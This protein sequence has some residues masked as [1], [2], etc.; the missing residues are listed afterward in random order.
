MEISVIIVNYNVRVFLES[1]LHS[2]QKG[3]QGLQGEIFVVDNASQD[4][5]VAM[6][7]ER[8]P[9]IHLIASDVNLGFGKANNRAMH[10]CKGRYLLILNPDTIIQEDTLRTMIDFMDTHP[11]AGMAGCKVLNADGTFQLSC[12][13]GF[14]TPW[15]SFCKAFGLSSIFPQVKTFAGYNLT[16]LDE[17]KSYEIDALAGS[18]MMVRREVLQQTG[19]FDEDYFMYGEDLDWC[20]RTKKI[21]WKIWYT[22]ATQIIHYKGESAKRSNM[23]EVRIFYEAMRIFVRKNFTAPYIFISFLRIG[24]GM[25]SFIALIMRRWK[26]IM[27]AMFDSVVVVSTL[28]CATKIRF[29]LFTGLPGYAYPQAILVP[30]CVTI[31]CLTLLGAYGKQWQSLFRTILA[32]II[33]FLFISSLTFFFKNYA[34]SRQI[35]LEMTAA[36]LIILGGLRFA[37]HARRAAKKFG[38]NMKKAIIFGDPQHTLNA[39]RKLRS[40][41]QSN[42]NIIGFVAPTMESIGEIYDGLER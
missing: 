23:N 9:D 12:R 28:L 38:K 34:F 39:L 21:G 29:G 20:Y 32:V 3:M 1:V 11:D 41:D 26:L 8:F 18:F 33:G 15:A 10:E 7:V 40:I 6:I 13:R 35:V 4:G 22:P 19:G 27:L 5:S 31:G 14:P 16:Y 42:I 37:L 24:I 36:N 2:V 25:R 17:N 30:F